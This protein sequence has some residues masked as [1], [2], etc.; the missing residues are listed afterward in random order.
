PALVELTS[1]VFARAF[2]EHGLPEERTRLTPALTAEPAGLGAIVAH[3]PL[4]VPKPEN[5][6]KLAAATAANL[7]ALLANPPQ[8]RDRRTGVARAATAA[9]V[10]VL[11]RTNEQC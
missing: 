11:C 9:D 3:W 4:V 6:V 1:D 2:V 8:V 7:R 10:A 5:K